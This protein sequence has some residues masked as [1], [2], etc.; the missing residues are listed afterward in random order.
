MRAC[1][2]F[3][4]IFLFILPHHKYNE[5][6]K[7]KKNIE[8]IDLTMARRP[9][10]NYE[11]LITLHVGLY[12]HLWFKLSSVLNWSIFYIQEH[13]VGIR[14]RWNQEAFQ[15]INKPHYDTFF[16][17]SNYEAGR[18][19]N[20]TSFHVRIWIPSWPPVVRRKH[21]FYKSACPK[22]AYN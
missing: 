21:L 18:T 19:S 16:R 5:N 1:W 4:K 8:R 9:K 17:V 13:P 22:K 11:G 10:G 3:F 2:N 7:K 15:L 20:D 14:G 12:H 6:N